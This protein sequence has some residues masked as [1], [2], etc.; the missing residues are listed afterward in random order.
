MMSEELIQGQLD[1]TIKDGGQCNEQRDPCERHLLGLY[2]VHDVK[3]GY[4]GEH[5]CNKVNRVGLTKEYKTDILGIN[6]AEVVHLT[7]DFSSLP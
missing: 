4:C 6:D 2:S 1:D 3:R 7:T 5:L